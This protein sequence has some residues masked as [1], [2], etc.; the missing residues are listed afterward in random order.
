M[1]R[2]YTWLLFLQVVATIWI[3]VHPA[4]PDY[5]FIPLVFSTLWVGIMIWQRISRSLIPYYE[6]PRAQHEAAQLKEQNQLLKQLEKQLTQRLNNSINKSDD[7]K[8]VIEEQNSTAAEEAQL[9][10]Q[11]KQLSHQAANAIERHKQQQ[12]ETHLAE[13]VELAAKT[14]D[15]VINQFHAV[16]QASSFLK[17]NFDNIEKS[18]KEIIEHLSDI[19]KINE[20]TNLLALNAAIEAARAG[21]SGRG[22]SVVAD[23]V[24]ALSVRTDEFNEKIG[25]K[26]A[27]TEALFQDSVDSLNLSEHANMKQL[28]HARNELGDKQEI[29]LAQ[30]VSGEETSQVISQVRDQANAAYRDVSLKNA[31]SNS[32]SELANNIASN[33]NE[34]IQLL[35]ECMDQFHSFANSLDAPERQQKKHA[36]ISRLNSLD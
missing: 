14:I 15:Q 20:Q 28:E 4:L 35:S 18:F 27:E 16:E 34:S 1:K 5:I 3:V 22:F 23:E 33:I 31:K 7:L 26:I 36:L 29:L 30:D 2:E 6:T 25:R 24:R 21:D 9:L 19:N 32:G 12:H 17:N 10:E 13:Y 11:V 8:I